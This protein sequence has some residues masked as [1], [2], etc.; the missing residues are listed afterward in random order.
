VR[1]GIWN[2]F[3]PLTVIRAVA[4]LAERRDDTKL[5][6]LGV[7]HPNPETEEMGMDADAVVLAKEL[8][9]F[10][11]SVLFNFGWVP[12]EDP[13]NLLLEAD[14][15]V[16]PHFDNVKTATAVVQLLDDAERYDRAKRPSKASGQSSHG[17]TR[18][19]LSVRL[20]SDAPRRSSRRKRSEGM[21]LRHLWFWVMAAVI[22]QGF[23]AFARAFQTTRQPRVP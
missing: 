10:G 11:E 8:G 1:G 21:V 4:E 17:R 16:S 18:F 12:Y 13:M 5:Y 15:D 14:L 3:D 22:R 20:L 9:V 23:R 19:G 7:Q 2:W 6:F